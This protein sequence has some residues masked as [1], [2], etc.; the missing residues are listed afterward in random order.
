MKRLL[1]V[2]GTFACEILP[3]FCVLV[4]GFSFVSTVLWL[5]PG[6]WYYRTLS[7][8]SPED[9]FKPLVYLWVSCVI[10]IL[11]SRLLRP[12]IKRLRGRYTSRG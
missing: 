6:S 1:L 3:T 10:L 9:A 12:I 4:L 2:V 5:R 7:E 8:L 11:V